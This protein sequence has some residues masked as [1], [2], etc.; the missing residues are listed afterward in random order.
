MGQRDCVG[1]KD[2][3]NRLQVDLVIGVYEVSLCTVYE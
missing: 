1:K 3:W 2:E